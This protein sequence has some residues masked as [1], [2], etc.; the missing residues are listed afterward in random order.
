ML[1]QRDAAEALPVLERALDIRRRELGEVHAETARTHFELGKYFRSVSRRE[2][3]E[4]HFR[5]AVAILRQVDPGGAQLADALSGLG[6][7]LGKDYVEEFE[8]AEVLLREALDIYKVTWGEEHPDYAIAL[9]NLA[10]A[11]WDLERWQEGDALMERSIELKRQLYG[12]SHPNIATS[13]DNLA[14]SQRRQGRLER[15]AELYRQAL[16]MRQ[17][18]LDPRHPRVAESATQLGEVLHE[19]SRSEEAEPFLE[20]GA[21][22]FEEQLPPNHPS[23]A[24]VFRSLGTV[25]LDGGSLEKA[26]TA[27][28]RSRAIYVDFGS[29]RWP[30]RLDV[31][32]ARCERE[33]G[34]TSWL[35]RRSR[36]EP[37]IV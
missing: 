20:L 26:R 11:L 24:R 35:C 17:E 12:A 2:E 5:A 23:L 6:N 8:E 13:L 34:S 22:I 28:L 29:S 3:A 21:E 7:L 32:L 9:N 15:A 19:L 31:L 27:L 18:V 1:L 36:T 4:E 14:F 37:R 16:T 10:S 30:P 25:W 33:L